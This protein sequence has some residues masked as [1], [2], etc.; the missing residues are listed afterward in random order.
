[1][2]SSWSLRSYPISIFAAFVKGDA[3]PALS[4]SAPVDLAQVDH[5]VSTA[6]TAPQ[7]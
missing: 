7:L 5:G 6:G 1:M 4:G 3:I 2:D